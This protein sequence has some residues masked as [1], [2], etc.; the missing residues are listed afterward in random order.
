MS[1]VVFA[2]AMHSAHALD[3]VEPLGFDPELRAFRFPEIG[4]VDPMLYELDENT[5]VSKFPGTQYD[6]LSDVSFVPPDRPI[7]SITPTPPSEPYCEPQLLGFG[8]FSAGNWWFD[9]THV[10]VA[11]AQEISGDEPYAMVIGFRSTLNE[12]GSTEVWGTRLAE[13]GSG[14]HNGDTA[15]VLGAGSVHFGLVE[16]NDQT[17]MGVILVPFESDGSPWGLMYDIQ[18]VMEEEVAKVLRTIIE[19]DTL[20]LCVIADLLNAPTC[21]GSSD[22]VSMSAE[23]CDG[24]VTFSDHMAAVRKAVEDYVNSDGLLYWLESW[25]DPD[26]AIQPPW[27]HIVSASPV[28]AFPDPLTRKVW[29]TGNNPIEI[30]EGGECESDPDLHWQ[31]GAEMAQNTGYL[32]DPVEVLDGLHVG[33]FNGDGRDDLLMVGSGWDDDE[34]SGHPMLQYRTKFAR[35]NNAWL[36][37]LSESIDP[38]S[39]ASDTVVIGDFDGNCR[40][41]L[42]FVGADQL[43]SGLDIRVRFASGRGGFAA[44]NANLGDPAFV[45]DNA[46]IV[47]DFTGDD[48]DDIVLWGSDWETPG[49]SIRTKISDFS[50]GS[51]SF[52]SG[53]TTLPGTPAAVRHAPVA[54]DVDGDGADDLV[55]L[56]LWPSGILVRTALSNLDGTYSLEEEQMGFGGT[57]FFQIPPMVGDLDGDGD[58]D[59]VLVLPQSQHLTVFT[60]LSIGKGVWATD[61]T[62]VYTARN[63]RKW[64]DRPVVLDDLNGDKV[65]DLLLVD[66]TDTLAPDEVA[67][68]P[69]LGDGRG[70]W[71]QGVRQQLRTP[72]GLERM[73]TGEFNYTAGTLDLLFL[74]SMTEAKRTTV[75]TITNTGAPEFVW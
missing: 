65:P 72:Y 17:F 71:S 26:D 57:S 52:Y 4:L 69:W 24:V 25:A 22:G 27:V 63:E 50:N 70:G 13:W 56:E 68:W 29:T 54:A 43:G 18:D 60:F 19:R 75:V 73:V 34:S 64:G 21:D 74:G 2:L 35:G 47:G 38:V 23:D 62:Q 15:E 61:W 11:S 58:E 46:P 53:K 67:L 42:A 12:P 9:P 6:A 49:W 33:D 31:I 28:S 59:L 3:P 51:G 66:V 20:T 16:E 40:D 14:M 48:R 45:H 5:F 8:E 41:D 7:P 55:M 1:S 30:I 36:E 44:V 32:A 39:M 10:H 37:K